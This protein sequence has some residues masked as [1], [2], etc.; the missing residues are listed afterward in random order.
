M[1]GV[2]F[3]PDEKMYVKDFTAPLY[4]SV[5]KVVDGWIEIVH[6]KGLKAPYCMVINE[7][8]LLRGL[9]VNPIGSV[10]YQSWKHGYP[11]VGNLVVLK[12]GFV[13]GEP[14]IVGLSDAEIFE[15]KAIA[16]GISD[17]RIEEVTI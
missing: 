9:P 14:D 13:D 17:C 16:N 11:I 12:D 15:I 7:E 4:Q 8:G 1:K 5:G 2:V 3:T 10:W 6:P